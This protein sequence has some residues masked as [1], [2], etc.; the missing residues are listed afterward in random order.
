[1]NI[2]IVAQTGE[3]SKSEPYTSSSI[4]RSRRSKAAMDQIRSAIRS[5]LSTEPPMTV[6]QVFYQLVSQNAIDK[7]KAEYNQVVVRLLT[8]NASR[9]HSVRLDRR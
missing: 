8:E 2:P 6:R 5:V 9:R 3:R 1:M 4:K 7:T